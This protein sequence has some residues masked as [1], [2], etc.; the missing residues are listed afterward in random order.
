MFAGNPYI[1]GVLVKQFISRTESRHK[2]YVYVTFA[3]LAVQIMNCVAVLP[4]RRGFIHVCGNNIYAYYIKRR[5]MHNFRIYFLIRPLCSRGLCIDLNKVFKGLPG[6]GLTTEAR[7]KVKAKS[8]CKKVNTLKLCDVLPI[9]T[10]HAI[11][12]KSKP[13]RTEPELE[14]ELE[15]PPHPIHS[16]MK[17]KWMMGEMK[18]EFLMSCCR[19]ER[20]NEQWR[21]DK[22]AGTRARG[23][24][25]RAGPDWSVGLKRHGRALGAATYN[26]FNF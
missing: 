3:K 9:E 8:M 6:Q 10:S 11:P 17:S 16:T 1:D 13:N 7:A 24:E 2:N 23:L 25:T 26:I 14:L 18:M 19:G 20:P 15:P 12:P 4:L 21:E 22:T 5:E